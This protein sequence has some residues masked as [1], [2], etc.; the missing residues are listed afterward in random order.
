ME[1]NFKLYNFHNRK[2]KKNIKIFLYSGAILLLF[3]LIF[4]ILLNS[5]KLKFFSNEKN[6]TGTYNKFLNEKNYIGLIKRLDN[7]YNNNQFNMDYL[8]YRGYSYFLLAEN[9]IELD[10]KNNYFRLALIDLRRA[11]AIGGFE[12]NI[13]NIYFC[14][15]KIYYYYGDS[16]YNLSLNY[17][18]KSYISGN[19]RI[20]L[21][22]M[23]GVLY[24]FTGDY[25]SAVKIY[26]EALKIDESDLV[27]LALSTAYFNDNDFENAKNYLLKIINTSNDPKIK[28]KSIYLMGEILFKEKK[29]DEA[30]DYFNKVI[31][32]NEN[33][34][35]AYFYRG[36]IFYLQNNIFK[37][38]SDWRK[39]L[40][41]NPGNIKARKRLYNN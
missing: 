14:I 7:D 39:T 1:D 20:D 10:K 23:M 30:F 29:I 15:G 21:L 31:E 40:E 34:S 5:K 24:S 25:K 2:N 22:F 13:S 12:K 28:E 11:L 36:E 26:I 38:R 35:S 41:L 32:L 4:F 9:E 27:L 3:F 8:I 18:N 19:R 37:A 17:F 16:Y 33:N 6:Q